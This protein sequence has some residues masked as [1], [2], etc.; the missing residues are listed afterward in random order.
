MPGIHSNVSVINNFPRITKDVNDLAVKAVRE[1]AIVG[2]EVARA[3]AS[4]RSDTGQMADIRVSSPTGSV[5][6]FEAAFVSPV[7]YSWFQNYGTLGNR[8]KPLKQPG[9]RRK[10]SGPGTGIKPLYFLDAGKRAGA[11]QMRAVIKA[12]LARG[13]P[14]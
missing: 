14:R 8:T 6:G 1:A 2:G 11:K 10:A 13:L 5:D 4:G 12:G 9:R 7:F 3:K